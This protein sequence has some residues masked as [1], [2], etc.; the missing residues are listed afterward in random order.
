MV[1]KETPRAPLQALKATREKMM[2]K[3]T[4]PSDVQIKEDAGIIEVTGKNGKSL[5]N[6][7]HLNIKFNINKNTLLIESLQKTKKG[8][9]ALKTTTAHIKNM[10][11][12]VQDG[13][14]KKLK[15]I[16]QHFPI[17]LKQ[18]GDIIIISNFLGERS[19]R[20]AKIKK[21][22]TVEVKGADVIVKGN[23][24]EDVGCTAANIE[25]ATKILNKDR[26]VFQ[27]GIFIVE[28]KK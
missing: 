20:S 27:D 16:Y 24:K 28:D 17:Q 11:H 9:R 1:E 25:K 5:R 3:I 22:T 14:E 15:I 26:R 18:Q 2:T 4:I 7:A 13:W 8:K 23:N 10:I 6:F 12:G 19:Q 21:G